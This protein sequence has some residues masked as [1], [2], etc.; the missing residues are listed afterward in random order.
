MRNKPGP[1]LEELTWA[2]G[3]RLPQSG[4]NRCLLQTAHILPIPGMPANTAWHASPQIWDHGA[5]WT[6]MC[7]LYVLRFL[8]L[9]WCNGDIIESQLLIFGYHHS[10][11]R[12]HESSSSLDCLGL[13]CLIFKIS[14][15]VADLN[16]IKKR[17]LNEFWL[18][19]RTD[20]PT[21][22]EMTL[23]VPLPFVLCVY[24]K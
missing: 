15:W 19:I 18:K 9:Q 24:T 5:W 6:E 12:K 8:T 14:I 4:C 21:I 16:F 17:S 3:C 10:S 1:I 11:A 13:Q 7:L 2:A 23:N 20:F 22:S